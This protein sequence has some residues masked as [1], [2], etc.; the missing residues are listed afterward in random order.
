MSEQTAESKTQSHEAGS[1]VLSDAIEDS[2]S[3]QLRGKVKGK[4]LR[5]TMAD[6]GVPV[7]VRT[8]HISG[9]Y[10]IYG[11][12]GPGVRDFAYC[13]IVGDYL[14]VGVKECAEDIQALI[15][16]VEGEYTR[17]E[18]GEALIALLIAAGMGASEACLLLSSGPREKLAAEVVKLAERLHQTTPSRHAEKYAE[19]VE[20]K[21]GEAVD[22]LSK[23]LE[24]GQELAEALGLS[25]DHDSPVA[26]TIC[27]IEE[28]I[29]KLR[30]AKLEKDALLDKVRAIHSM[31]VQEQVRREELMRAC[32]QVLA[33]V[34]I[35][36]EDPAVLGRDD[37]AQMLLHLRVAV[38]RIE[39]LKAACR[40]IF[41]VLSLSD[42]E[43]AETGIRAIV[44]MLD[45]AAVCIADDRADKVMAQSGL[46]HAALN[47]QSPSDPTL[48]PGAKELGM[49]EA[50]K[51]LRAIGM[52][53]ADLLREERETGH[54]LIA[55]G[56]MLTRV[57][58][59]L[60]TLKQEAATNL[61]TCDALSRKV[62]EL[63]DRLEATTLLHKN[64]EDR[65]LRAFNQV[66]SLRERL[67]EALDQ[68]PQT[69]RAEL[70]KVWT[71]R[72]LAGGQ[73]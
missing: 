73:S 49:Q 9:F 10:D 39:E 30:D 15:A 12:N 65:A 5:L 47:L 61:Q 19:H 41:E 21:W 43:G 54:P 3:A 22:D 58:E 27:C 53:D 37:F 13:W 48:A 64:E 72:E 56:R 38:E 6:G 50:V 8:E 66:D 69:V 31:A 55:C 24:A 40:K 25:Y 26:A 7:F 11:V 33:A 34:G 46:L 44:R 17:S 4:F 1:A 57:V 23:L 67:R 35:S 18:L 51:F 59:R 2:K 60:E 52:T 32:D 71:I 36:K 14:K 28:A 45:R 70:E 29:S 62:S 63:E 68:L 16:E 42:E 20:K